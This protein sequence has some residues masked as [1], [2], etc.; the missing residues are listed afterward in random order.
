MSSIYYENNALYDYLAARPHLPYRFFKA[1]LWHLVYG[2]QYYTPR[3]LI[4]EI[5]AS[6]E[7]Y[8]QETLSPTQIPAF[9]L[10]KKVGRQCALPVLVVKYEQDSPQLQCVKVLDRQGF[11]CEIDLH[12]LSRQYANYGLPVRNSP[13]AKYLNDRNSSAYH[14]WQRQCLGQQLKVSDIDLWRLDEWG[15]VCAIYELKRSHIAIEKWQPYPE[16]YGNF[17][18]LWNLADRA[19]CNF[20]L[21]YNVRIK[22]PFL[23]DIS[24][25][26]IFKIQFNQQPPIIFERIVRLLA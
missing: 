20:L 14:V 3:L 17:K 2:D 11:F 10:L 16:D 4:L 9:D 8:T 26:K 24:Q 12:E 18:L 13:T 19:K 6:K 7:T 25:I 21:L 1:G 5:A 22:H 23:D 15:N